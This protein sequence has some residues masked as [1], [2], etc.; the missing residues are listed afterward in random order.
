MVEEKAMKKFLVVLIAALVLT[1]TAYSQLIDSVEV[2]QS[3]EIHQG[4]EQANDLHFVVY[5]N[6]PWVGI[7][8]WEMKIDGTPPYAYVVDSVYNDEGKL[9]WLRFDVTFDGIVP[10]CSKVLIDVKL[11]LDQANAIVID[12]IYW[13]WN[14]EKI[15]G[16]NRFDFPGVGF[17]VDNISLD[18]RSTVWIRNMSDE[19]LLMQN[20]RFA[21]NQPESI[22]PSDLS[23]F[24][25]WTDRAESF[26]SLPS[27][28]YSIPLEG[29][30]PGAYLY[31]AWEVF[32]PGT[33]VGADVFLGPV[34]GVHEDQ[35][36]V[37]PLDV[38][39]YGV[40]NEVKF[41]DVN[42]FSGY[43]TI[44]YFIPKAANVNLSVYAV[45]GECVAT[46]V[47]EEQS[48]GGH[49]LRWEGNGLPAGLYIAR[50]SADGI[51]ASEKMIRLK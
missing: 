11:W 25:D 13:T 50:L 5:P 14:G 47:N 4:W 49:T 36:G 34:S 42:A 27:T 8:A 1:G 37:L 23:T 38:K 39:E 20:V 9:H 28:A 19:V 29:M 31:L 33:G 2:S 41:L 43:S 45:T 18:G 35:L 6:E 3:V 46:L 12:S 7:L 16:D 32:S 51:Q 48:A 40:I 10:F 21:R 30:V 17:S 22:E 15:N 26:T 44:Q 24:A